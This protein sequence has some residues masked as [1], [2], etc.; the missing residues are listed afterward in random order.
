VQIDVGNAQRFGITFADSEG[1]KV[2]PVI[3]HTAVIGTIERWLYTLFDTAVIMEGKGKI[4]CL[5]V[6]VTPEQVRLMSVSEGHVSRTIELADKIQ[7]AGIR[8]TVDDRSETV[9]KKVRAAKQDWCSYA[10]VVGDKEVSSE[11]VQVYDRAANA[12]VEM[13][14]DDLI[15]K[16]KAETKGFPFRP[17]YM[18]REMSRQI[19][20]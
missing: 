18:P 13:S 7:A 16:V 5:P 17:L 6:W 8:V 10:I 9:G 11:M 14:V 1:K 2:Y 20:M 15:A 3:L 12:N 4:G 19:D